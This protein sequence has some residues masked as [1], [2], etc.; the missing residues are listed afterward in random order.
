MSRANGKYGGCIVCLLCVLIVILVVVFWNAIR[1]QACLLFGSLS[2]KD[3]ECCQYILNRGCTLKTDLLMETRC[4]I[5]SEE[6]FKKHC[7]KY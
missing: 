3:E 1:K 7:L 2:V 5:Y 4:L 6:Y